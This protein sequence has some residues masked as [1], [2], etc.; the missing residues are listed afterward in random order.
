[1]INCE[2]ESKIKGECADDVDLVKINND[3]EKQFIIWSKVLQDTITHLLQTVEY[4]IESKKLILNVNVKKIFSCF[5]LNYLHTLSS[6]ITMNIGKL[7]STQNKSS[8]QC[9]NKFCNKYSEILFDSNYSTLFFNNQKVISKAIKIYKDK[10]QEPR[11]KIFG[12]N[13]DKQINYLIAKKLVENVS[14]NDLKELTEMGKGV[15][16]NIWKFYNGH[17]MCFR[18]D[19][20]N[21]YKIINKLINNYCNE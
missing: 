1:M 13:D 19:N 4:F 21:D 10:I 8:L 17:Q 14:N 16:L 6:D 18:L 7:Y 12:H 9:Y 2:Y 15:L 20:H 5:F 11:N 3:I